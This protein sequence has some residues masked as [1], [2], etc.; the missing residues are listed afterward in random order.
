MIYSEDPNHGDKGPALIYHLNWWVTDRLLGCEDGV[1]AH[2]R[3]R[4]GGG[5]VGA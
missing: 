4:E 1:K 2:L 3:L 5:H